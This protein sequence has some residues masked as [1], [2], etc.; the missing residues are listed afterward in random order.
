MVLV[1][2][3]LDAQYD[4]LYRTEDFV[5]GR[6]AEEKAGRQFIVGANSRMGADRR[7]I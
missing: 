1:H 2:G 5:E 6:K 7:G 4:A 3:R